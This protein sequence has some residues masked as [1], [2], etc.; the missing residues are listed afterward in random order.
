MSQPGLDPREAF[1]LIL[2]SLTDL[3]LAQL[4]HPMHLLDG[5]R[6]G[7]ELTDLASEKQIFER[8]DAIGAAVARISNDIP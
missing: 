3:G 4:H 5:Q 6:V 8:Q 7:Q 1:C 2:N